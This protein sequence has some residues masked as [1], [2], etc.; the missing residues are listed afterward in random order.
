MKWW[1][2]A[3]KW[4]DHNSDT[5]VVYLIFISSIKCLLGY[6]IMGYVMSGEYDFSQLLGVFY[7]YAGF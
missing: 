3:L 2:G 1:N 7:R 4:T 6:C 5:A